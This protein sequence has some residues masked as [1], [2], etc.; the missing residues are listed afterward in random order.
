MHFGKI[1]CTLDSGTACAYTADTVVTCGG[2]LSGATQFKFEVYVS[3]KDSSDACL[4]TT[5]L[6]CLDFLCEFVNRSRKHT[7]QLLKFRD[8]CSCGGTALARMR[9]L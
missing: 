5:F 4:F 7:G 8:A 6:I 2:L 1:C 3:L 9:K